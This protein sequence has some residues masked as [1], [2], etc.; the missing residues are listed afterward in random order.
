MPPSVQ[1]PPNDFEID[2]EHDIIDSRENVI[3]MNKNPNVRGFLI[4]V[5]I[6]L[7][8]AIVGAVTEKYDE[9]KENRTFNIISST[10][11]TFFDSELKK[12]AKDNKIDVQIDYFGDIEIVD[13]LN[14]MNSDPANKKYDAVWI[15][16]SIWLYM[17]DNSYLVTDSKSIAIN[18]VVLAVTKSKARELGFD[19]R[20]VT[21]QDILSAIRNKQLNYVMSSVTKTNTGASSYLGFLN[22][23]AG[24]PEVLTVDMLK[25]PILI[26]DMKTL[27][28]GVE[29]VSGDELYLEEMFLNG[30]YDAII[31]YESSL[32][33]INKK[34]ASQGKEPLY[35]VYPVDGV[36][37]N[38]MPF[39]YVSREQN[40]KET[41]E[42][43]LSF[44]RSEE[45]SKTL[46]TYGLRTWYGGTNTFADSASFKREWGIDTNDYLI[47]LKYPSKKVI[48]EALDIY[49]EQLRKP[50]H[51]VFCLDVSGS[52]IGE[53]L[54]ELQDAMNYI[55]DREKAGKD[56]LQFSPN[57]RI[58]II[59][60][61]S[62]IQKKSNTFTGDNTLP[63]ITFT[64]SLYAS[65]GTNIYDPA[66]EALK[67]LASTDGK[68]Y[69]RTV[70]LMTDGESNTGSFENLSRYYQNNRLDIPIY[71]IM[72]GESNASQLSAIADLTNAKVF[73]GKE[74]LKKAFQEVRSYN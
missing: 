74:G 59:T 39:G 70:I 48:T 61:N 68:E 23:L 4:I 69:T 8:V 51:T 17:L 38:D 54:D 56:R 45:T 13:I 33:D 65:G 18:P 7:I 16:N 52:M 43:F 47:P 73:D 28:T 71:S 9:Y 14:S 37:I 63:L 66:Q 1:F 44:L 57:D 24:S 30:S 29:R 35:L 31:N 2:L 11:N 12:F 32:I 34:L 10:S 27:F 25:N 67:I 64:N 5:G 58:S 49:V 20:D 46:E 62:Q 42:K 36:S 19:D 50:N 6:I 15:S 21:N 22:S 41:F 3:R 26:N 55:L 72:F 60:F 53:G 40:K